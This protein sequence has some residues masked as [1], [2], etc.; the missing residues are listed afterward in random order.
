L[1]FFP[2]FVGC[3]F[4]TCAIWQYESQRSKLKKLKER[5]QLKEKSQQIS[6]QVFQENNSIEKRK[7][8]IL[9]EKYLAGYFRT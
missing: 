4:V 5:W 6:S 1:I 8:Y 3:T 2:K 7:E 9:V